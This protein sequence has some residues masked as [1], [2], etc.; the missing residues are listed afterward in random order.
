MG[1]WLIL[2]T[3]QERIIKK[4]KSFFDLKDNQSFL[5]DLLQFHS[6]RGTTISR[7]PKFSGK[8]LNLY[9]LYEAVITR[10]GWMKVNTK[11]EWD[12]VL[13]E[14]GFNIKCVNSEIALKHFYIR[15]FDKYERVNFHGEEKERIDDEDDENRHKRWS[16][17]TLHSIPMIYNYNQHNV[18]G[19]F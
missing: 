17:R 13:N 19:E 8:S 6:V 10:G 15:I 12:E 2:N 9:K 3:F 14:I 4:N 7:W 16:V 11:D 1:F 18:T 5:N